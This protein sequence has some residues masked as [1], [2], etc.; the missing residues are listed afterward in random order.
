MLLFH[1]NASLT[2]FLLFVFRCLNILVILY[3][4]KIHFSFLVMHYH[5]FHLKSL[6]RGLKSWPVLPVWYE[7][8]FFFWFR[9]VLQLDSEGTIFYSTAPRW[10][11][12]NSE[13]GELHFT[14]TY[15]NSHAVIRF[16]GIPFSPVAVH[17][18]PLRSNRLLITESI[19]QFWFLFLLILQVLETGV[20]I[21]NSVFGLLQGQ[22]C[23]YPKEKKFICMLLILVLTSCTI[24][25]RLKAWH[26]KWHTFLWVLEIYT[27][28]YHPKESQY[29]VT[30][31]IGNPCLRPQEKL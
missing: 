14:V 17:S 8:S 29:M 20:T 1:G 25:R 2:G 11:D 16:R 30:V 28:H 3:N 23:P 12:S 4:E 26:M 15:V 21:G 6:G 13:I 22:V 7:E 9:W 24:W 10:I 19:D 27:S 31:Y 18:A 5:A